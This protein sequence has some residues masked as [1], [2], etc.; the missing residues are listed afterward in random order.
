[1]FGLNSVSRPWLRDK[2]SF[3]LKSVPGTILGDDNLTLSWLEDEKKLKRGNL[4][5]ML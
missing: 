3:S 2:K 5:L 4:K 1:M